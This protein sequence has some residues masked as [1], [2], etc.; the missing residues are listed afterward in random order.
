M[1]RW[2]AL[3]L[4]IW[5]CQPDG[6]PGSN[7]GAGGAPEGGM[8]GQGGGVGGGCLEGISTCLGD[9]YQICRGGQFVTEAICG[10]GESCLPGAGCRACDPGAGDFCRDNGIYGCTP[11]GTVTAL[12]QDCGENTCVNGRCADD[13][14]AEGA[15]LIYV[16]DSDYTL[17][18]F[19][20][21]TLLL[22][23]VGNL[24]C[25][26]GPAWPEFRGGPGRPFSM[27]V[28][29]SGRAWVLFSSGEIFW[30]STQTTACSLAPWRPGTEGFEL[31]GMSFVSDRA[32]S[33]AETL[34]I[35]GGGADN[36]A[37]ARLGA[38]NP[39]SL[40]VNVR[41]EMP[42]AENGAELTGNANG[43]LFAYWPGRQSAIAR[44]DKATA[45]EVERWALPPLGSPPSAWAFA[46]WG[47]K[48]YV[49]ISTQ[50]GLSQVLRFDPQSGQTE[51]VVPFLGRR[52]VGAGVSTCAPVVDN[53]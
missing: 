23:P 49:F 15:E 26:A 45:T 21:R 52:I 14:C 8:A 5:G 6:G 41:G 12:I 31:F 32:G 29:R 17:F 22:L 43:E 25:P 35:S 44:M 7:G 10:E 28:D 16:V 36:F 34:H 37:D 47:G 48:Y 13:D 30:V 42:F 4:L 24:N 53:F 38:V 19:D 46:H 39:T 18:S 50:D 2:A 3:A 1:T 27:A 11:D 40:A 51:T 9:E 20:P 33:S